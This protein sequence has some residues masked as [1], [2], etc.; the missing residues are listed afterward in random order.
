MNDRY[1]IGQRLEGIRRRLKPLVRLATIFLF[2]LLFAKLVEENF[3]FKKFDHRHAAQIQ[4]IFTEKE[5]LLLQ[6]FDELELCL[7]KSNPDSCFVVFHNKYAKK[8]T[9]RGLYF[10]VYLNDT[11]RYWSSN[12]AAVPENFSSSEFDKPYVSLGDISYASGKYASFVKKG[13]ASTLFGNHR[14]EIVGLALIKDVYIRENKYLK[15]AFQKDFALPANVKIFP[16]MVDNSFPITD[17]DGQFVWSLIFDSTCFYDYQIFL[18]AIAYLLAILV[19]FRLLNNFFSKL[20]KNACKKIYLPVAAISLAIVRI[21][22]QRWQIPNV[23]YKLGIFKPLYFATEWFPSLGELCIWCIFICFF[24]LEIYRFL[25]F[26]VSYKNKWKYPVYIGISM[27]AVIVCFFAISLLLKELAM[28]S[29][30]I[31]EGTNPTLM[32]NEIE[33]LGYAIILLFFASFCLLL[34]KTTLLC[35]N[36]LNFKQFLISYVIILSLALVVFSV[37]Q[38][39]IS[40]IAIFFLSVLFF[41]FGYARLKRAVKLKYSHYILLV[42]ILAL[43]TSA[44]MSRHSLEKY[45]NNK[46]LLVTNLASQHDFIAEFLLQNISE[47]IISDNDA[48]YDLVYKDFTENNE[49]LNVLNYINKS[50]FH[51]SYWNRYRFRCWVCDADWQLDFGQQQTVNCITFFQNQTQTTGAKLPR[52]EF[53]FI[54]QTND[55]SWYLGWFRIS[56]EYMPTLQLF[57]ELWPSGDSE[58]VGYPELLLDDRLVAGNNLKG[59]SYAKYR[60]N[61]RIAQSGEY[62]YNLTGDI[63]QSDKS[64]YHTV[65]A[66]AMEHLVYRTDENNIIVLS[67]FS[68]KWSDLL[69]NFSYIFIFFLI[70]SSIIY[71]SVIKRGI[72]TTFRNKI[73]YSMIG[74]MLL[75]FAIISVFTVY[76]VNRQYLDKNSDIVSEKM[77]VIH[78]ELQE[79]LSIRKSI[80]EWEDNDIDMLFAW[81]SYFQR[82]FFT[83]INL[84]DVR[85][86]LIAS[87]SPEIFD[88]GL[89]GRQ[90]NPEAYLKL[91]LGKQSSLIEREDI[92][93]LQYLSAYEIFTDSENKIIAFLN[94]PYFTQQNA[95]TEEITNVIM[96]LFNFYM[97]TILF[98]VILSVVISKQITQPLMMLQDKFKNIKLGA[99]NEPVLYH[100]RDE[101][102]GLVK[103]YNRAIDELAISAARLARS[104]RESA[105]R[106]M[107]KQIA[108]EIN[109]P[110]TPMKLSIQ[111]LKR[112]YDNKSERFDEYMERI[113]NSL[114]EQIDTLSD[115]ATEFSNFAK[116]PAP[117]T[118]PV[119]LIEQIN[120]VVPLFAIDENRRAFHT[121]FHGLE[122]AM[123]FADKE[124]ISRVF[125]NLFKNAIEAIPK[126]RQAMIRID[127]QKIDRNIQ[128]S[129]SDNGMGIPEK[130][131]E[132]I[133]RPNLSTKPSG[134]GLGLSIV[135]S[136]IESAGG[137]I[138][139]ETKKDEGTRFIINLPGIV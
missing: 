71:I 59:F 102:G 121:N 117:Q 45:E 82:L 69:F 38:V 108:H 136:I 43:Y 103:E 92:G 29:T 122:T 94:L 139:F 61:K 118:E 123:I 98:T 81:L 35:K 40:L 49:Y 26:P 138:S 20:R 22:M 128:V 133:F 78:S 96:V 70:V 72:N 134:M 86:Q 74:V 10:F 93:G 100:S 46:R 30:G 68:R 21:A 119:D 32:L 111:H 114:V 42:V 12:E 51:S 126:G 57:I 124:H 127:A 1:M 14:Y 131:Q 33:L 62:R 25:S 66:D 77:R 4:K 90:I 84:F 19:F 130:M 56:K 91:A 37:F 83:D 36:N 85:G 23:F 6:G 28:N 39:K 79:E 11:L 5:Q 97:L 47:R 75:S 3:I 9:N 17:S 52:S 48:I 24:V 64:D 15:T 104:E 115:I 89:I 27:S 109:N 87:S 44:F 95:L 34:D 2:L 7:N 54:E 65:Y 120:K 129:I 18:P 73:Q 8:Q 67:S 106:E 88:K 99:Q 63:F 55:V 31:F 137:N 112:A 53:W 50:Y 132:N 58:E 107:A 110:L 41:L 113:S 105:W 16:A 13:D 116:M 80:D 101:L 60:N 76:Y 135:H 125:I